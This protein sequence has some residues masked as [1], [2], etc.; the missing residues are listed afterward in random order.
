M[1]NNEKWFVVNVHVNVFEIVQFV[2]ST[3]VDHPL[4]DL[5]TGR[6]TPWRAPTGTNRVIVAIPPDRRSSV[7]GEP[8]LY[9]NEELMRLPPTKIVP[10]VWVTVGALSIP[11]Q[12]DPEAVIMRLFVGILRSELAETRL[13]VPVPEFNVIPVADAPLKYTVG[14]V[15]V[16]PVPLTNEEITFTIRVTDP[17]FHEESVLR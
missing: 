3:Y 13:I 7:P 1:A 12:G 6:L 15:N 14:P 17:V 2:T 10:P 9:T 4:S 5:Y 11:F 16:T 8:R